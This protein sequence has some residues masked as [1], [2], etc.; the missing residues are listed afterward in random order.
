MSDLNSTDFSLFM[1]FSPFIIDFYF[2]KEKFLWRLTKTELRV[3]TPLSVQF[4]KL[5]KT[6]C[7]KKN[8]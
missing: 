4:K 3:L 8:I 6:T 2:L 5:G 7:L 1:N